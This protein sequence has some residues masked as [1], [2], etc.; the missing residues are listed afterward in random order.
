MKAEAQQSQFDFILGVC[1][2]E[3]F[4]VDEVAKRLGVSVDYVYDLI[5][6]GD[7][8]THRKPG[9]ERSSQLITRRS[10]LKWLAE[11]ATYRPADFVASLADLANTLTEGERTEL[12]RRIKQ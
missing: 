7:L 3:L 10:V 1:S 5:A 11:S 9:R 4:R 8:E 2:R 6:S 12:R